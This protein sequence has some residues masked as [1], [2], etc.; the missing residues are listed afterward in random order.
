MF[1]QIGHNDVV[2][3][4]S[5]G[6]TCVDLQMEW[7]SFSS[8]SR[9]IH[10]WLFVSCACAM[11]FRLTRLISYLM[12]QVSSSN[13]SAGSAAAET[14][15]R[16]LGGQLGEYLL[17]IGHKGWLPR[18]LATFT[19]SVFVPFFALWNF[20][21]TAWLWQ[22]LQE[23][24]Q[25]VPTTTHIWFSALWLLLTY[26]WLLVHVV[27]GIKARTLK[28]R[29]QRTEANLLQVE[30]AE[31]LA[32]WGPLSRTARSRDL[33]GTGERAGL[34]PAAIK[35]LP[36]DTAVLNSTPP[37]VGGG[38]L[39]D[40]AICLT[41]IGPGECIRCLPRCGHTFHRACIDL[42]LVRQADCPLCKQS[43]L[44]DNTAQ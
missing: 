8:C 32:R 24:P 12:A 40:C 2:L 1:H 26:M 44:E 30:D 43:V 35:A 10:K 34:S 22:V 23:T 14:G 15:D 9:P 27:L 39:R 38:C 20:L 16:R 13:T 29:A 6:Y 18:A 42:W 36:S 19:W 33:V 17:D 4:V 5:L 21:G 11:G 37:G 31:T 25:C 28:C 41:D 3:L 7:D